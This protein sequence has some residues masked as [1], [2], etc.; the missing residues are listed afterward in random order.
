MEN[1]EEKRAYIIQ[2]YEA[3][4]FLCNEGANEHEIKSF[5]MSSKIELGFSPPIDYLEILKRFDGLVIEGVF[6]YSTK[7]K[8]LVGGSGY[9]LAFIEMNKLLR[10]IK[11]MDQYILFGDS[12][13][14]AY[15]L[16]LAEG[17][18][19][20]RDKQA[21]DNVYEEFERFSSLLEYMMNLMASRV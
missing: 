8:K 17:R 1:L 12:D 10:E 7:P 15:V 5:V 14:D 19:Q 4:G 16:D 13:Q 20:V 21:F 2:K 3:N 18:Y 11:W 9:S 6:L